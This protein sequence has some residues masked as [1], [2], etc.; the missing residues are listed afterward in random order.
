MH[1]KIAH[2]CRHTGLS[3]SPQ[4]QGGGTDSATV[5]D[6]RWLLSLVRDK[7]SVGDGEP[8]GADAVEKIP[9]TVTY[10]DFNW[11]SSTQ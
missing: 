8:A 1:C 3:R 10:D 4:Q 9:A 11:P 6:P 2:A 5:L 7:Q